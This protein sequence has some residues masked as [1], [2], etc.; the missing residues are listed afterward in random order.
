MKKVLFTLGLV[1]GT[2]S[3]MA[4]NSFLDLPSSVP[5]EVFKMKENE[6]G[7]GYIGFNVNL[8]LED[9]F[10]KDRIGKTKFDSHGLIYTQPRDTET[11]L[12]QMFELSYTAG[13]ID[14]T[15]D[16]KS[17]THNGVSYNNTFDK[18]GFYIGVRPAFNHEL[19]S[20]KWLIIRNST[21]FHTFL[22]NLSGDFSVNNG[23]RSYAYD[24]TSYGLAMK[25]S[26]VIQFT[27]Y[28][29]NHLG[30][31]AFGGLTTFIAADYTDYS[32]GLTNVGS[33][34]TDDDS[35][36]GLYTTGI[37]PIVGFDI[38]YNFLGKHK[39]ALSSA[40]SKQETDN[41]IE[42]ILRYTHAF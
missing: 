4:E 33:T 30:V 5:I 18:Q 22:Y 25:P 8:E 40:I 39:L 20:N 32:G 15:L 21:A 29:T 19:Y 41:S 14:S 7:F 12:G 1:V 28:P 42:T 34:R 6:I 27:A 38:T 2:T 36:V 13:I 10:Y 11:F 24:E 9:D 35:E 26:S 31:T 17:F 23:T 16:Q 3:V 37:N